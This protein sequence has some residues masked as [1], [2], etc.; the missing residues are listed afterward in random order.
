MVVGVI[1]R[2]NGSEQFRHECEV[3]HVVNQPSRA[4]RSAALEGVR[5]H[6]GNAASARLERDAKALWRQLKNKEIRS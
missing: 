6:R 3:R 5:K 2:G 4:R 1:K